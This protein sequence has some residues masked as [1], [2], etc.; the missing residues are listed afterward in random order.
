MQAFCL[1]EAMPYPNIAFAFKGG[2]SKPFPAQ[3]LKALDL[4]IPVLGA[5]SKPSP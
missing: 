2:V 1:F 4:R 5:A 3:K